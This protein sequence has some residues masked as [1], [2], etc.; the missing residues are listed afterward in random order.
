MHPLSFAGGSA[1]RL[2]AT[3]VDGQVDAR[4]LSMKGDEVV[5]DGHGNGS[6]ERWETR[7]PLMPAKAAK[8]APATAGVALP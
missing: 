7:P 8:V 1:I 2:S 6:P 4:H 3:D 5:F